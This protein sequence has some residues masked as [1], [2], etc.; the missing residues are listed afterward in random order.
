MNFLKVK[1]TVKP[2]LL[3]AFYC[4]NVDKELTWF[5]ETAMMNCPA[6]QYFDVKCVLS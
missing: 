6:S 5:L 2:H 3:N 1:I 4:I